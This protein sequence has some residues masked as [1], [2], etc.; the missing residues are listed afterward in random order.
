MTDCVSFGDV[1]HSLHFWCLSV[2][3]SPAEGSSSSVAGILATVGVAL[4]AAAVGYFT[5]QKKKLC[6]KNRQGDYFFITIEIPVF[7]NGPHAKIFLAVPVK[8]VTPW[9]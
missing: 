5:Y 4:V 3:V 8:L 7:K 2:S 6:F 1:K 9:V